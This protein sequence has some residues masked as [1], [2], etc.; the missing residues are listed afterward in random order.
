MTQSLTQRLDLIKNIPGTGEQ[1]NIAE[2]NAAFDQI[3]ANKI[4]AAKMRR[5]AGT[6]AIAT[7]TTTTVDF[8]VVTY[9]T[10][11]LESEGAMAD[12]TGNQMNIKIDGI[13]MVS[14][15]VVYNT[16]ATGFRA[17]GVALNGVITPYKLRHFIDANAAVPTPVAVCK[18]MPLSAGD[19]LTC[20]VIQNS[21]GS[22]NLDQSGLTAEDAIYLEAVWQGK[23][24]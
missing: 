15:G 14:A 11:A 5:N 1:V 17:L 4:P 7:A 13:Y 22:V 6:Q 3:D 9:D 2:I 12:I 19:V 20:H 10:W 8:D 21:G 23:K 18:P 24:P 16:A